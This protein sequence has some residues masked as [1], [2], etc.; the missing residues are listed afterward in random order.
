[1]FFSQSHTRSQRIQWKTTPHNV[2]GEVWIVSEVTEKILR[3]FCNLDHLVFV[4]GS[5]NIEAVPKGLGGMASVAADHKEDSLLYL[6]CS[7]GD[8]PVL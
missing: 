8:I 5:F 1:M 7:I 2:L 6:D 3:S 4:D